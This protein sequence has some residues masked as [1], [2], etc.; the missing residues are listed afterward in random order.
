MTPRGMTF[1]GRWSFWKIEYDMYPGEGEK[2]FMT[3]N[4]AGGFI[5]RLETFRKYAF[6]TWGVYGEEPT[7]QIKGTS[8]NLGLFM[9]RGLEQPSEITDHASYDY[10]KFTKLEFTDPKTR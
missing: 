3:K 6:G 8:S 4:L 9:W 10:H 5:Q 7:L 1:N 2:L